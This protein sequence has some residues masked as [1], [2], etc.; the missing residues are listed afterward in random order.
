MRLRD[1]DGQIVRAGSRRMKAA[2]E[3]SAS[4][5]K[6]LNLIIRVLSD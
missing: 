3:A 6:K 2:V 1:E 5:A 4:I